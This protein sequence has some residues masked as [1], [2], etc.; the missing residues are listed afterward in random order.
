MFNAAT[1]KVYWVAEEN[2]T[3][4]LAAISLSPIL[5]SNIRVI[6]CTTMLF[7]IETTV[8]EGEVIS[9]QVLLGQFHPD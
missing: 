4:K 1:L 3:I 6:E 9:T 5:R 2:V 7:E 8:T